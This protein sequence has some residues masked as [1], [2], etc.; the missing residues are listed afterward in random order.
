MSGGGV[1]KAYSNCQVHGVEAP[2]GDI[3]AY[4]NFSFPV[5]GMYGA[6]TFIVDSKR[7]HFRRN[8]PDFTCA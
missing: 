3:L 8:F 6:A 2:N 5:Q 4:L 1:R 7:A